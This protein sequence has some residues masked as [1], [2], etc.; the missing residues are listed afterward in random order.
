MTGKTHELGGLAAGL[1][2]AAEMS[3]GNL[4]DTALICGVSMGA[5]LLPDIDKRGST[6]SN[7]AGIPG[8]VLR[9][10]TTHRGIMHTPALWIIIS[11]AIWA[12]SPAK[13][14]IAYA[15]LCGSFSHI[16]LDFFNPAGVPLLF[17]FTSKKFR[18]ARIR[19][20]GFIEY[21]VAGMLA[22]SII[23]IGTDL[24]KGIR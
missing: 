23:L 7:K 15:V 2:L 6:I 4:A 11:G 13:P 8:G 19:T 22:L 9:I 10:F 17:P 20:N 3:T 12:L 21:A 16:I 18:A 24:V 1:L 5:A 14:E